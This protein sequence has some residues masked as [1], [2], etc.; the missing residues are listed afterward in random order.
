MKPTSWFFHSCP[1]L[2]CIVV[3][4]IAIM[5]V[6]LSMCVAIAW[7]CLCPYFVE[8]CQYV[9]P[10][11]MY[12]IFNESIQ[13][14]SRYIHDVTFYGEIVRIFVPLVVLLVVFVFCMHVPD[15]LKNPSAIATYNRIKFKTYSVYDNFFSTYHILFSVFDLWWVERHIR[16]FTVFR[17]V[18]NLFSSDYGKVL[19]E[20]LNALDRAR[21]NIDIVLRVQYLFKLSRNNAY[22][23]CVWLFDSTHAHELPGKS[24]KPLLK[25]VKHDSLLSF[26]FLLFSH[27]CRS[28]LAVCYTVFRVE[29]LLGLE[30]MNSRLE[31]R[32]KARS[33]L[34]CGAQ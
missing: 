30:E 21:S 24:H 2:F 20:S 22:G 10:T 28:V 11:H 33:R 34:I 14:A 32:V 5:E 15:L 1:P 17:V 27:S 16:K 7:K 25:L 12:I 8:Y 3:T 9:T 19:T 31:S 6:I 4:R 23:R 26:L 29:S 18:K 13:Q